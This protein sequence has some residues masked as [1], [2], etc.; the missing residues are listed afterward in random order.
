VG[1]VNSRCAL[2]CVLAIGLLVAPCNSDTGSPAPTT[3]PVPARATTPAAEPAT[4]GAPA[5]PPVGKVVPIRN[6]PE[7]IVIGTSGI[8]AVA[9]RNPDGVELI[10]AATGAVVRRFR[11]W[12]RPGT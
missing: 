7:G 9:V 3:T 11:R 5:V 1:E 10:D 6:A 8:G 4:A 12:E 2:V